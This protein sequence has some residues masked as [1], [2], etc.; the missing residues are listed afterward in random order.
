[1]SVERLDDGFYVA[2]TG[3]GIPESDREQIFEA[4][5]STNEGGTGFGLRIVEQIAD[6]H[7]WEVTV[8]ESE[9]G[10]TR[11]EFSGVEFVD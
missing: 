2:D 9:H 11:F 8:T 10:G 5:Y 3:P 4:G 1:V 7:G 6:A